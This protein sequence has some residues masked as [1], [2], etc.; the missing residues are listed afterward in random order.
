[1]ELWVK[2]NVTSV[3]AEQVLVSSRRIDSATADQG[4][5][6][7][8]VRDPSQTNHE[9]HA[10]LFAN[11]QANSEN[12]ILP[13]TGDPAA[14]RHI[15]FVYE[16]KVGQ[17]WTITLHVRLAGEPNGYQ[18]GPHVV[19]Y[20]NVTSANPGTLRFGAGHATG[21]NPDRFF[22]GR[23]DNVAFYNA[24]LQQGDIDSHFNMF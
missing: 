1:V 9:I 3:A 18:D 12:K 19:K 11:G 7:R 2:P 4:Y 21:Q 14:W 5:E 17:G 8:L 6:I 10:R 22:A 23:I 15:V 24:A 13:L 20:Q 16:E